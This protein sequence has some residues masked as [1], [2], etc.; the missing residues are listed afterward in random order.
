MT[1]SLFDLTITSHSKYERLK[2]QSRSHFDLAFI[3]AMPPEQRNACLETIDQSKSQLRQDLFALSMLNFKQDGYFVE[4]G[5]TDGVELNNTWLM[6]KLFNWQGILAE[7]AN[8]WHTDLERNRDCSIDKRCVWKETGLKLKFTEAPIGE[9]SGISSF[10]KR[11]RQ[12]RGDSY[13]VETVSLNDLLSYHKAPTIIDYA[14]IDTEGSEFEILDSFDFNQHQFRVLTIE[15]NHT[16]AREDIHSLL[17]SHGYDRV[18]SDI[19]SF[20]DWYINPKLLP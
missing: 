20:D 18:F 5:A 17:T 7:P 10:V 9:Q 13:D 15:H 8:G 4:F 1:Y 2:E 12:L 19:S 6:N 16:S 14:S 11:T 3:R